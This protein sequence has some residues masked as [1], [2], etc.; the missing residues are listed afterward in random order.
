VEEVG[1]SIRAAKKKKDGPINDT[2]GGLPPGTKHQKVSKE[3]YLAAIA[4]DN[5]QLAP[6][7]YAGEGMY[8]T[9]EYAVPDIEMDP[10]TQGR[11]GKEEEYWPAP[12]KR[13]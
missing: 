1:T 7:N 4:A 3:E 10:W 9:D 5:D 2:P 8:A 6:E 11:I 12:R 13:R